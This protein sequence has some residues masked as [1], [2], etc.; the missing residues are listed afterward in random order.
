MG[1]VA[2]HGAPDHPRPLGLLARRGHRRR[3][4][5]TALRRRGPR[6][7]RVGDG[8]RTGPLALDRRVRRPRRS[9][10][11]PHPVRDRGS[12]A[13]RRRALLPRAR[14]RH[15]RRRRLAR[16][17]LPRRHRGLRRAA[18][19]RGHRAAAR[20]RRAPP[21]H[22]GGPRPGG[23]RPGPRPHR[24]VRSLRPAR[25]RATT[26]VASGGPSASTPPGRCGC[27]TAASAAP[28]PTPRWPPSRCGSCSTATSPDPSPCAPGWPAPSA[29]RR[30][31]GRPTPSAIRRGH[32]R[33]RPG[34]GRR[35]ARTPARRRREPHRVHRPGRPTPSCG[36]RGRSATSRCTTSALDVLVDDDVSD[37]HRWR[38]GL[39]QVRMDDFVTTV[40][41]ERLFLKGISVG[42]TRELL[43][44]ASPDEVA[45]DIDRAVDAGLDLVRVHGH[46]ARPELYDEADRR[47]VL[48]WQDLPIQWALQRQ[49]KAVGPDPGPPRRRRARPP[50]VAARVVRPPRALGRRPPHLARRRRAP[51]AA[52]EAALADRPGPARRGTA[53]C[54]TGRSP[55]R[56]RR[57]TAAAR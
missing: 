23:H 43:A 45:G 29:H 34:C 42:P 13:S 51:G 3:R 6:R 22:G 17:H 14:G 40:N 32:D 53:P 4:P 19:V 15:G 21:R 54:S 55:R 38:T 33:A 18:L 49:A 57:A 5:R 39:R 41:G 12:P 25:R 27:A 37:G 2:A 30:S 28:R 1:S 20:P 10:R 47:G 35:R 16:R 9:P 52:L 26:P 56:S 44:E 7:Q 50:P 46:I 11:L 24:R 31:P 48:L 36:G 8:A